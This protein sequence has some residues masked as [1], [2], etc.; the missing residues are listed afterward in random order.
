MGDI[1]RSDWKYSECPTT[2]ASVE[3]DGRVDAVW[4]LVSDISMPTRWSTEVR[5]TSWLDGATEPSV[6]AR[7]AGHNRHA[8]IGEWD[9]VC[10]VTR[11]EL[12]RCFE[13]V[14]GEAEHSA[15]VWRFVVDGFDGSVVLRQEMQMGPARSGLNPAIDAMPDKESRII[16]R[17]L[18]EHRANM[19]ANLDGVKS[20]VERA[21]S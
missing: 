12:G 16:A 19:Q 4:E 14:V 11:F 15:A 9:V 3:I 1:T 21:S 6:G 8:A 2:S 7:F 17:R 10:T 18:D 13:W 5:L 20:V